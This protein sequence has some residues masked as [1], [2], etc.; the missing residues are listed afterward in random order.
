MRI[1]KVWAMRASVGW[2]WGA[3]GLALVFLALGGCNSSGSPRE[4]IHV[5]FEGVPGIYK[6]EVLYFGQTVGQVLD[7]KAGQ[8]SIYRVTIRLAPEFGNAAGTQWAFYVDNGVLNAAP[9]G[10]SG[11]QLAAGDAVCGFGSK[12]AL[13]WFKVKTLLTDRVYKA[14]QKAESLSRR[15]G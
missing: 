10:G 3:L 4:G 2:I 13:N 12:A 14:S 7:Q 8:G 5:M 9:L 11:R 6:Q 15:F 1:N